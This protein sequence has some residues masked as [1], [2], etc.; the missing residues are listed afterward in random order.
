[1]PRSS[2][3]PLIA[4][5]GSID[6]TRRYQPE[7]RGDLD[8]AEAACRELGGE[9]ARVG[10][11][12]L[13]FSSEPNFV[14]SQTAAG[15][16]AAS[17]TGRI[18]ARP[19]RNQDFLLDVSADAT[20]S[21]KIVRDTSDEWEVSFYRSLL[22][23]D[24]VVLV[25]GGRTT[26]IAGILAIAQGMPLLPLATF[27]GG[28][29]QVWVNLDHDRQGLTDEDIALL[30]AP[31]SSDSARLLTV[32]VLRQVE[33]RREAIENERQATRRLARVAVQGRVIASLALV[34][35]LA[36]I[37]LVGAPGPAQA[38]ALGFVLGAPMLAAVAGAIIRDSFS[39]DQH[40]SR[41]AVRGLG[42]GVVTVLLYVASQL[43]SLPNLFDHLDARRLLFFVIPLGFGAGFTFDLVF[44]RLRTSTD[45]VPG[46]GPKVDQPT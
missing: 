31:W 4:V 39:T 30:G 16:S 44:D 11:D 9:L 5:A 10:C 41:A 37:V 3:R 2:S 29:S 6:P 19:A 32:Y 34:A 18:V 40:W 23:A 28:A 43:L 1:M 38:G 24:A 8:Q 15:Y 26:R 20:V 7:L 22:D 36:G 46:A 17:T 42:A 27:G 35:A 14:E 33:R 12:L 45:F 13:L 25:G 21:V